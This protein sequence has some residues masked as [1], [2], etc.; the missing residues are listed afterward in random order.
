MNLYVKPPRVKEVKFNSMTTRRTAAEVFID[1]RQS[2]QWAPVYRHQWL[3]DR[4]AQSRDIFPA[5]TLG[6]LI[7]SYLI[8]KEE[9]GRRID[10]ETTIG[11]RIKS[12]FGPNLD[13]NAL[14]S[15]QVLAWRAR[16]A[17][18]TS[19]RRPKEGGD[20][21]PCLTGRT[22]N[23]YLALLAAAY[24]YG[25]R[26]GLVTTNPA[27]SALVGRLDHVGPAAHPLT[28]RQ[29][30]TLLA[31][32]D[33][34]G[35]P[36]KGLVILVYYTLART[37]DVKSLTWSDVNIEARTITYRSTKNRRIL[38]AVVVPLRAPALAYLA[39]CVRT[40]AYVLGGN[41]PVGDVRKAWKRLIRI[42]NAHLVGCEIPETAR[43]YDL[44]HAGATHL[45][46]SGHLSAL[47]VTRLMGD[48]SVAT[49]ERRYFGLDTER[50]RA[51]LDRLDDTLDK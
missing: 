36:V 48:V 2:A 39:T 8:D 18:T 1:R 37:K 30:R 11:G 12:E 25:I 21:V 34:V 13:A 51:N 19:G 9:R 35:D 38:G 7:D 44:R 50:L 26:H 14:T 15:A 42:A 6:G 3:I 49:V 31:T 43:L 41:A 20:Q 22:V 27:D 46:Q 32:I 40:S 33:T 24:R 28:D 16:L 45:A 29:V 4:R 47:E 23:G 10:V 5:C 17:A